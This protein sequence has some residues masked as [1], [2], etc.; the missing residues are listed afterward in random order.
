MFVDEEQWAR[1]YA[2]ARYEVAVL[3]GQG[4]LLPQTAHSRSLIATRI[5]TAALRA[6]AQDSDGDVTELPGVTVSR[7]DEETIRYRGDITL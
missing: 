5:A 6:A 1:A 4:L 2:A 7:I 3:E